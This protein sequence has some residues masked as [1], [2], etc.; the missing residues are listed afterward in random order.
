MDETTLRLAVFF[1][2]FGAFALAETVTPRRQR[3]FT[4]WGRWFTNWAISISNT[5]LTGVLKALLG[6]TAALAALD[7]ADLGIGLF[8]TVDWPVWL[9]VLI[10][11]VVLDFA[12]WFQHVLSHKIPILWRLHRVHHADRDF[13]VTTAIR[14]HPIEIGL[15]MLFKV[16]LVY[17]L[18]ASVIAVILF[19][20]VLNGAAMF[21]H[22]N[23]RLPFGWDRRLRQL[24]V[25]PDMHRVHHSVD[26]RE[27]DTNYGFNLS[28]WDRLFGTYTAQPRFGHEDM[29]IGLPEHQTP[30][31]T[32][33]L[34]S[35]AFPFRK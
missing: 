17:A 29:A 6:V 3:S 23:I 28:I 25:T 21:N 13:D 33:F 27:H 19:E 18:G 24:I 2:L 1:G 30:E 9:E 4:R 16:A 32:Q 20:I 26:R 22:A 5:V 31:P 12:I 7:A 10:V 11:F 15:S 14:F 35:L 34:W 8:N